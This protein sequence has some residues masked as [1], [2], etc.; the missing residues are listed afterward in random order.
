[1]TLERIII[2]SLVLVI[3][4][5]IYVVDRQRARRISTQTAMSL[6]LSK[7]TADRN[8]MVRIPAD[9][10]QDV[11]DLSDVRIIPEF[12]TGRKPYPKHPALM[13]L[14]N[15]GVPSESA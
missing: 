6:Y 15:R 11:F 7:A 2:A 8:H 3:L 1:M 5:L 12:K 13:R 14:R 4:A 10:V 9:F